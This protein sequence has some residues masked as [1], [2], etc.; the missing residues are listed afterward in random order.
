[1]KKAPGCLL[2]ALG[3]IFGGFMILA[4]IGFMIEDEPVNVSTNRKPE[5]AQPNYSY[6]QKDGPKV[7]CIREYHDKL[8]DFSVARDKI[9]FGKVM[10]EGLS[11]GV[12]TT[13]KVGEPVHVTDTAVFSGIVKIRR[14]GSLDEYWINTES[15]KRSP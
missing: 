15:V 4:G 13:F 7:G 6:I 14:L 2:S 12:C 3:V 11:L 9:A 10:N 8:V 5:D 1:M